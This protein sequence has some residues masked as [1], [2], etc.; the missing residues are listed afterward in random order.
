MVQA[1]A[2][3]QIGKRLEVE[4]NARQMRRNYGKLREWAEKRL[5]AVRVGKDR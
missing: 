5:R 4:M 3:Q 2:F 1:P